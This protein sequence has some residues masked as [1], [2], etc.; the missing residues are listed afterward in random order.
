LRLLFSMKSILFASLLLVPNGFA[1]E[2]SAAKV[3]APAE[4]SNQVELRKTVK[5]LKTENERLRARVSELERKLQGVSL[6][7]HLTQEEQRAE[8]LQSQ[9]VNVAAQEANLQAQMDQ[10]DEQLRPAN[11][12]NLP[13][14]GSLRPEE[15]RESA[16][17]RLT[18]D[19]LRI[20]GQLDVIS[21]SKTRLQSSLSVSDL[22]IQNLRMQLQ[23][24][25]HP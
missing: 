6:R 10:V 16:R 22:L 3:A 9:L 1:Q 5:Q 7:D 8:N 11:I 14:Y 20:Q 12:D 21:Q 25:L 2:P 18:N 13:V 24:S 4:K 19:K 17:R 15:V 23:S